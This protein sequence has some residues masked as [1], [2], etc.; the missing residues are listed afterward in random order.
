MSQDTRN[1]VCV[2][3]SEER[4]KVLKTFEKL[5]NVWLAAENG[6]WYKTDKS[7][8]KRLF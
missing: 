4:S 6:Y 8:W 5:P 1:I 3:S 7:G 2:F